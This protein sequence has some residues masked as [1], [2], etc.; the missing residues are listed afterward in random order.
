MCPEC[1]R[2]HPLTYFKGGM[3][4][5]PLLRSSER[6]ATIIRLATGLNS[7][8]PTD[9]RNPSIHAVLNQA[10]RGIESNVKV[11]D[12]FQPHFIVMPQAPRLCI[13]VVHWQKLAVHTP[14]PT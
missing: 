8:S 2:I 9:I 4:L 5:K 12:K 14:P 3:S 1:E 10:T 7:I 11:E 6:P 13:C